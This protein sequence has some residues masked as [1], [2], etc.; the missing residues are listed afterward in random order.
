MSLQTKLFGGNRNIFSIAALSFLLLVLATTSLADAPPLPLRVY[1]ELP[2][3]DAGAMVSARVNDTEFAAAASFVD[4]NRTVYIV[5]VPGD[6]PSTPEV[7]GAVDGAVVSFRIDGIDAEETVNWSAG[8]AMATDLHRVPTAGGPVAQDQTVVGLEDVP[9][10]LTLEATDPDDQT[11]TFQ[12]VGVPQNGAVLGTPPN[13]TYEPDADWNGI[14]SFTFEAS[15]GTDTDLGTVTIT[16]DPVPDA[17]RLDHIADVVL[18]EGSS[19]TV[20]VIAIDPDGHVITLEAVGLPA[21]AE[22]AVTGN[23]VGELSFNPAIG[24]AGSY[25]ALSITATDNVY[26]DQDFFVLEVETLT[27]P[28]IASHVDATTQEDQAVAFALSAI[29]PDGDPI[30]YQITSGP[31]HGTLEGTAPNLTYVPDADFFGTDSLTY[32]ASDAAESS[33]PATV[34]LTVEPVADAPRLDPVGDQAFDEGSVVSLQIVAVD[35]DGDSVQLSVL[36]LPSFASFID[37]GD[38]TGTLE[39]APGFDDAGTYPGIEISAD[40]GGL[41]DTELFTLTIDDYQAPPTVAFRPAKGMNVARLGS[42]TIESYSSQN[43]V[44][45]PERAIDGLTNTLWRSNSNADEWVRLHLP[46]DLPHVIQRIVLRGR[47]QTSGARNFELRVST[48]DGT[49]DDFTLVGSGEIPQ[50]NETH[51][52]FVSPVQARRVELRIVDNWGHTSVTDLYNFELWTRN[53]EGGIVSLIADGVTGGASVAGFSSERR[54]PERA[55]D[56][57]EHNRWESANGQITDQWLT[58]DLTGEQAHWV[59]R[60]RL[61]GPSIGSSPRHFEVRVSEVS[62]DPA[63]LTTVFEGELPSG[64]RPHWFFFE[65][66]QA[67][68]VQ[69]FIHDTHSNIGWVG[70]QSFDVYSPN[71]GSPTVPFDDHSFD[72]DGTIVAWSWDFGDGT[73]STERHPVHTYTVP[74]TYAVVLT[75]TDDQGQSSQLTRDY[76]VLEPPTPAFSWTPASVLEGD[77]VRF[78]DLSTDADGPILAWHWT[79]H[80]GSVRTAD[81]PTWSYRDDG[82][83]PVTLVVTDSQMLTAAVTLEVPVANAAPSLN[84]IPPA[85]PVVWGETWIPG[86]ASATDPGADDQAALL[87]HWDYGDGNTLD[88]SACY[89]TDPRLEYVYDLPGTYTATLTVT[90]PSG[91]TAGGSFDL[92]VQRRPS[93]IT[94]IGQGDDPQAQETTVRARLLDNFDIDLPLEG[95]TVT[96]RRG[97]QAVDAVTDANGEAEAV[98]ALIPDDPDPVVAEFAG[99]SLYLADTGALQS[100]G[101]VLA[102][103]GDGEIFVYSPEGQLLDVLDTTSDSNEQSGMCFDPDGRILTTNF[104]TIVNGN[105]S[106]TYGSMSRFDRWGNRLDAVWTG[107]LNSEHPESCVV[108]SNGFVYVGSVDANPGDP[109]L[110]QY[111]LEGQLV[112]AFAPEV[113]DRGIDWIDLAADRC[114]LF[115]TSEGSRVLRFDVCTGQQLPDFAGGLDNP[116]YAL[117]IRPNGEVMV[118]SHDRI[119]RLSPTGEVMAT[120]LD[121]LGGFF[122]LNLDPDGT[123]FWTAVYH[124]GRIYRVDIETGAELTTFQPG[125]LVGPLSGLA[126]VGELTAAGN[127][128]PEAAAG[129]DQI[130][131]VGETV[132]LDGSASS[133]PDAGDV[134]TYTWSQ[135]SGPPA[136]L[137]DTDTTTATFVPVEAGAYVFELTVHDGSI[138]ATDT[139]T[140]TAEAVPGC[141][142]YPFATDWTS[143]HGVAIDWQEVQLSI[144]TSPGQFSWLSWLSQ[145]DSATLANSLTPP[146]DSHTYVHPVDPTDTMLSTG[147]WVHIVGDQGDEQILR[148]A[149][150]ILIGQD[151]VIPIWDTFYD[152]GTYQKFRVG[153]FVGVRVVGYGLDGSDTLTI[154]YLGEVSCPSP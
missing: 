69:L 22:L 89:G 147:D 46:G 26:V 144:G 104:A 58:V 62:A 17:P 125:P 49:A 126:V 37:E 146:G 86:Q 36:G 153:T 2:G 93:R 45:G 14:D 51:E 129:D 91:E 23:G 44:N 102:G 31:E 18:V 127:R 135:V 131:T 82:S 100:T 154:N 70:V 94:L 106:V 6:D 77:L 54:D 21:F 16:V 11:L 109:M 110:R 97:A 50:D 142:V 113:E 59:D 124:G 96:F 145:E 67:R 103:I 136:S 105:A 65:P 10:A 80:D 8:I 88:I 128:T 134:L 52:F 1:G 95:R 4:G 66:V 61:I 111:D 24:D 140:I 114:T 53:R 43:S 30:T 141:A 118:A 68:Y 149:L 41:V 137:T 83:W 12:I 98:L 117:R 152:G 55:F 29:D 48:T 71:L 92:E 34:T 60:V 116:L 25:G 123:S 87:C 148:D 63:D 33:Q 119:Y 9:L 130:V 79:F 90:D 133:D 38:G 121:H 122:G 35:P 39:L 5:D 120:Y 75:V 19:L 20:P 78:A 40:D 139:V 143:F 27:G 13:V 85:G 112:A 99:D 150:D 32:V 56:L 73:V 76:T 151:I 101:S 84:L 108:D 57:D 107:V 115:Y 28:P 42:A 64:G 7:E 138:S 74:G 81:D 3:L 132:T 72:P 15:D 47:G